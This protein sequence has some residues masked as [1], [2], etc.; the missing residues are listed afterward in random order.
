MTLKSK[1]FK[2]GLQGRA[3]ICY[4]YIYMYTYTCAGIYLHTYTRSREVFGAY[5]RCLFSLLAPG[6]RHIALGALEFRSSPGFPSQDS[7]KGDI[8]PSRAIDIIGF[9][10]SC[11]VFWSSGFPHLM[12]P[13]YG[14]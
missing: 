4:T 7:L 8:G 11:L 2:Y 12:S 3:V 9:M 1:T 13:E 10:G 14:P 5:V 6:S